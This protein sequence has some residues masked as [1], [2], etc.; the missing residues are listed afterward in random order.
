VVF[1]QWHPGRI[2][3]AQ[4]SCVNRFDVEVPSRGTLRVDIYA[5]RGDGVPDFGIELLDENGDV[6]AQPR[7][8]KGSPRRIERQLPPGSYVVR[9]FAV[10]DADGRL[11]YELTSRF[12][13]GD[14]RASSTPPPPPPRDPDPKEPEKSVKTPTSTPI[15]SRDLTRTEILDIETQGDTPTHVLIDAGRPSGVTVGTRGQLREGDEIVAEIEII[16]VYDEGS[17]ARIIGAPRGEVTIFTTAEIL[18]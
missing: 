1:G 10:N 4:R 16:E 14:A 2:D 13:P 8:P 9:V 17:R 15:S 5:H 3:C 12:S 18:H 11:D 6:A 7:N